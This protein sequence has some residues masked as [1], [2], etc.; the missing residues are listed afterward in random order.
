MPNWLETGLGKSQ[1]QVWDL[2]ECREG[3]GVL[4]GIAPVKWPGKSMV[5]NKAKD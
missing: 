5:R 1:P 2:G 4:K 3:T